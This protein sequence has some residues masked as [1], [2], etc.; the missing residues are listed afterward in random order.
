MFIPFLRFYINEN[1]NES[2]FCCRTNTNAL[3]TFAYQ[4]YYTRLHKISQPVKRKFFLN[5]SR[6]SETIAVFFRI[7]PF[8]KAG[9]LLQ[10]PPSLLHLIKKPALFFKR[11]KKSGPGMKFSINGRSK[12]R[13]RSVRRY[14]TFNGSGS[15]TIFPDEF[16]LLDRSVPALGKRF[17]RQ[18]TPMPDS[19]A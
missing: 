17:L 6:F 5:F 9:L 19:T 13:C 15:F 1:F 3:K 2:L 16:F 18:D 12:K 7:L 14:G 8:P 4:R 10:S 11:Y